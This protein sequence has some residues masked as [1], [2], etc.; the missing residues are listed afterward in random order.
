MI[1][2]RQQP[3]P[4]FSDVFCLSDFNSISSRF[5]EAT[6]EGHLILKTTPQAIDRNTNAPDTNY[7]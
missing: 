7:P 5:I 3:P 4:A 6:G 2:E 1:P